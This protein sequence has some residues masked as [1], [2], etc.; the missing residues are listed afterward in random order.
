MSRPGPPALRPRRRLAWLMILALLAGGCL[1]PRPFDEAA[2]RRLV[3]AQD[4]A[5]LHAPHHDP[6][7][8]EFFNPWLPQ[9]RSWW[10]FWRWV[11]SGNS[12]PEGAPDRPAPVEANSG[13]YLADPA[14]PPSLTWIGH[15]TFALQW[16]GPVV[17]TDPFFGHRAAIIKRLLPPA[18]GPEAIPPGAVALISHNHY[19][20]L[21]AASVAALGAKTRFL[22]P[23]GLAGLL[24]AMGAAEVQELDWWQSVEIEGTRFTCLP[25]QHWSRR[26]GQGLNQ[27]LWCAWLIERE[28][29]RVF[30]GA[31]SGYFVGFKEFG[32]RWPGIDLALMPVGAYLPR[33]FMHYAHMDP[34]EVIDASLDLGAR[35]VVPTQWGVLKL[36]DEPAAWPAEA[37]A[38]EAAR[39]PDWRGRLAIM[40]VGGRIRLDGRPLAP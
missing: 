6:A 19:D 8:G 30:Y 29:R 36:G 37:L 26:F 11:L 38:Q 20:H 25:A 1:A 34:A 14:A 24:R 10:E 40:P 39:R 18:F 2:W 13:A 16:G 17:L 5:A 12:A 7:T 35:V 27:S 31:D 3:A 32:R 9:D 33:W 23:L 21:D 22:C 15:A 4:P 28:G